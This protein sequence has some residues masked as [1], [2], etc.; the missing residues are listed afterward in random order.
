M[1][2]CQLGNDDDIESGKLQRSCLRM[3]KYVYTASP[4]SI[5]LYDL[6]WPST[7]LDPYSWDRRKSRTMF[8]TILPHFKKLMMNFDAK[9]WIVCSILANCVLTF[10]STYGP[11]YD[12]IVHRFSCAD[13]F[14]LC[15]WYWNWTQRL[16]SASTKSKEHRHIYV[17]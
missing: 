17:W 7:S 15:W 1:N 2:F 11:E 10:H 9:L 12:D 6:S 4:L 14:G 8:C 13:I 5:G 3:H 16:C